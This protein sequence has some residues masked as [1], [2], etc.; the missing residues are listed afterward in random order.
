M[1][2]MDWMNNG[3]QS[4]YITFYF[5]VRGSLTINQQQCL[6]KYRSLNLFVYDIIVTVT[7]RRTEEI[8]TIFYGHVSSVFILCRL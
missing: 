8:P 4:I 1:D 3:F 7:V 6:I 5:V 2:W